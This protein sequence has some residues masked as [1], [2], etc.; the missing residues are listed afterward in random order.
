MSQEHRGSVPSFRSLLTTL[1]G[2]FP[3]QLVAGGSSV[4]QWNAN[5]FLCPSLVLGSNGTKVTGSY[6]ISQKVHSRSDFSIFPV[7]KMRGGQKEC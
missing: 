1:G 6:A 7:D 5:K 3:T 4:S 2:P